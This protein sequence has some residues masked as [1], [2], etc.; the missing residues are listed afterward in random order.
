MEIN[1]WIRFSLC[2]FEHEGGD[3]TLSV[4][5]RIYEQDGQLYAEPIY[6]K[7]LDRNDKIVMDNSHAG[8]EGDRLWKMVEHLVSEEFN[9]DTKTW[10]ELEHPAFE[11][12][13]RERMMESAMD[14]DWYIS[15][16]L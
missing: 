13:R 15:R 1:E 10:Y 12:L 9:A 2:S 8:R 16:V 7:L 6:Y 11:A 4:E 14:R 5:V 3:S